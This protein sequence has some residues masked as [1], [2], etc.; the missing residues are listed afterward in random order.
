MTIFPN[1][2]SSKC[3]STNALWAIWLLLA[4]FIGGPRSLAQVPAQ[5]SSNTSEA[6]PE[7]KQPPNISQSS[8]RPVAELVDDDELLQGL[9]EL[10]GEASENSK[11]EPS[12]PKPELS[13]ADIGLTQEQIDA[14]NQNPLE[15]IRQS[16]LIAAGYLQK[17]A[18]ESETRQ[19]QHD[20]VTR[21][22]ELI[23]SI[24]SQKRRHRE[25][26]SEE[27]QEQESTSDKTQQTSGNS[28]D[29]PPRDLATAN[30]ADGK[31]DNAGETTD[32]DSPDHQGPVASQN[33]QLSSPRALL[34]GVWGNL[35]PRLRETMQSRMSDS[36]LPSY[37]TEIEAYYRQLLK[38]Q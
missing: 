32:T 3:L 23:A 16:M 5:Q 4:C 37:Q 18:A 36:F 27:Q 26:Q 14:S 30:N 17:G 22:D 2:C 15:A 24:E 38:E 10:I 11:T 33:V 29:G 34:Q 13:P 6:G 19:I 35:P 21:L 25:S 20:I 7:Q 8:K 28:Q 31:S 9:L 12:R 1:F